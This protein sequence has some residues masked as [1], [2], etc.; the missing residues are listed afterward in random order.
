LALTLLRVILGVPET[1]DEVFT[2]GTTAR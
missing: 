1:I 2:D